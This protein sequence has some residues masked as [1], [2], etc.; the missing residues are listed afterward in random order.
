M[1]QHT[2]WCRWCDL[3]FKRTT[4]IFSGY[5]AACPQC[6]RTTYRMDWEIQSIEKKKKK[7]PR[8]KYDSDD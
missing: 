6:S 7:H 4:S 8:S 3:V 5:T 2:F 1:A